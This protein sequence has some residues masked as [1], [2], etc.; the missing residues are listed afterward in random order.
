MRNSLKHLQRWIVL[1]SASAVVLVGL[2]VL[3]QSAPGQEPTSTEAIEETEAPT[4]PTSAEP[5]VDAADFTDAEL[6]QFAS[7]IP[8]LQTLQEQAQAEVMTLVEE[9]GLSAERYN[10]IAEAQASPEAVSEADVSESEQIAFDTVASGIQEIEADFLSQRETILE[11]E[12]LTVDRYKELLAA[13]QSDP[14]L[15]QQIEQ[16]L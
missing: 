3:A 4:A 7:V 16:M 9:S 11:A 6:E 10:E 12:G 5:G 2:P 1:G 13:V 8:E 14:E 15:L